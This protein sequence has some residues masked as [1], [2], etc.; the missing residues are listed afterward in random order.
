MT[1][2]KRILLSL[3]PLV[4]LAGLPLASSGTPTLAVAASAPL[5]PPATATPACPR[6]DVPSF[7]SVPQPAAAEACGRCSDAQC[8]GKAPNSVCGVGFRCIVQGSCTTSPT[9]AFHCRCLII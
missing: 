4:L 6:T 9:P 8:A 3:A 1:F 5:G 2:G 7:L